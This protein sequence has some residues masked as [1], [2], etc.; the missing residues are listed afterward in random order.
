MGGERR[1]WVVGFRSA[2]NHMWEESG[3]RNETVG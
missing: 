1:G 3:G 2:I